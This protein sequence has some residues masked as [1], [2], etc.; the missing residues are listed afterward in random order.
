MIN[1]RFGISNTESIVFTFL[2]TERHI[3][4]CWVRESERQHMPINAKHI[5]STA[6][7]PPALARNYIPGNGSPAYKYDWHTISCNASFGTK[8][9]Q[10]ATPINLVAAVGG[11]GDAMFLPYGLNEIHSV[12]IP[13]AFYSN[14]APVVPAFTAAAPQVFAPPAC[15]LTAG[16]SGC[17]LFVDPVTTGI[18]VHHANAG[19]GAAY[20]L[21]AARDNA[22][23]VALNNALDLQH[24]TALNW[25][26]SPPNN[27]VLSGGARHFGRRVY[28]AETVAEED[29]Q[30]LKGRT[31]NRQVGLPASLTPDFLGGTTV[32]G[33]RT[34][35]N[36][37]FHWQTAGGCTYVDPGSRFRRAK[38]LGVTQL[39]AK[40]FGH[41]TFYP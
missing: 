32:I 1:Q 11:G 17:K 24:T 20:G 37:V 30:A 41:G 34:G 2:R 40:V 13:A 4:H 29:R 38:T 39:R 28:R 12:Y 25:Y 9:Y 31:A 33:I 26:T 23:N 16:M 15:F 19:F 3:T 14:P 10:H 35:N 21:G 22:E 6:Y 7:T 18:I 8:D 36:W 27:L 5:H